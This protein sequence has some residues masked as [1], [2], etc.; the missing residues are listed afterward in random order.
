M[1]E[2]SNF[3][4]RDLYEMSKAQQIDTHAKEANG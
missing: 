1:D 4:R 3:T 2:L